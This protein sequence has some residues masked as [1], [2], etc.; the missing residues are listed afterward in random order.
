[1]DS[2]NA[3]RLASLSSSKN[4]GPEEARL[5]RLKASMVVEQ[6]NPLMCMF[7]A[8]S[9]TGKLSD[10]DWQESDEDAYDDDDDSDGENG[11]EPPDQ[12]AET[13]EP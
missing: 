12:K 6:E 3:K 1:M 2:Y 5:G 4:D 8:G 10:C 13:I 7:L 11:D 9:C